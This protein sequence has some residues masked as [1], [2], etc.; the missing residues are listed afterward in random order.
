MEENLGSVGLVCNNRRQ[1]MDE[2][3][4]LF[5]G[6]KNE[7]GKEEKKKPKKPNP[8]DLGHFFERKFSQR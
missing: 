2:L 3:R 6:Q 1:R 4:L 7:T 5:H 8:F